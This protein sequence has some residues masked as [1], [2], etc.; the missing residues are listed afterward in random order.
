[1]GSGARRYSDER[2]VGVVLSRASF[3]GA[4][5]AKFI[6]TRADFSVFAKAAARH[7]GLS[8]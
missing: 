6:K 2:A 3:L 4:G 1:M 8:A 5:L 7:T